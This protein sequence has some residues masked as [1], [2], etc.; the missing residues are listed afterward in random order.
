MYNFAMAPCYQ[1]SPAEGG[2]FFP[3]LFRNTLGG[4][5]I[6]FLKDEEK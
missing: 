3:F 6:S 2:T 5:L 1:L 4:H